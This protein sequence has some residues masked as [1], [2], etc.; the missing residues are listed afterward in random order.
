MFRNILGN[1]MIAVGLFIFMMIA[2]VDE[3]DMSIIRFIAVWLLLLSLSFSLIAG[4]AKMI[5][6]EMEDEK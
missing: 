2:S 6:I 1:I 4:G 3:F 5:G